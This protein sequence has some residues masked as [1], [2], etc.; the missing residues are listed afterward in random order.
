MVDKQLLSELVEADY[1]DDA[2]ATLLKRGLFEG[3][4]SKRWVALGSMPNNQSV[5]HAQQ[6]T[7]AAALVEKFTNGLDAI[8]LR[9]CKAQAVD[10]RSLSAPNNMSRAVHKWFG[11][12]NEKT[13]QEIRTLAEENLVLYAT[14]SKSRPCVSVYDAGEGQLPEN[15]PST[16]CS[17]IYGSDE[18]SYKGAVPFVQGRFNMGGTGVLPFC[19]DDRKMQLIVSRV[20]SDVVKSQHEWGFTVFCFFPSRQAPSWKYLVGADGKIM[21]AGAEPLG[22]LP[23]AGAKSGEICAPR[24]RKVPH[25]T[26]IKMYDYK[27]PRS[28]VC[29][30]LFK[31]LE[32]YLLRPM[33][34]LRIVE[35]RPEYK[36]NVMGVTVWDRFS[37]WAARGKLEEGF[38][39]GAGI[40]IKLSSGET[41]PAE[42]RVFKADADAA[43]DVEHPQTGLRALINGQSHARRDT[44]FFKSKAVDKEHIGGSMLVTLDCS[45]LGQT[46]R[47]ALFMSNRETF[48]EDPLLTELFKKLQN[49]L[50]N[51]EGL[52]A[53]DKK[54]YLEKIAKAT[55]D[56]DGINA[57][58]EL[59]STDP[60]L[61][62]LFG[63]MTQGKVAAKTIAA[64]VAGLKVEGKAP[65]FEG[66]EFPSY[67]KRKD[68]STSV[69][70]ELPQ[71]DEA[72][73]SFLTDVKNNYFIR[74]RNKGK[75]EFS[76]VMEPT[77]RLFNGR[78]TFTFHADKHKKPVGTVFDTGV[79]IS[80]AGHGPWKLSIK[81]KVA[82]P[83]ERKENEAPEPK[84][85]TDAA[86]SRPDIIDVHTGLEATPITV[87]KVPGTERLQLLVN[88]DSRLLTEAKQRR[89]PE[90]AIAV[91]FVFKYGLA[92]VA[93]GL[94]DAA[95]RTTEWSTN[96]VECRERI[97]KAAAGVAR[98]I[99]PLCLTLPKKLPKA[100]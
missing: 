1:E 62:D 81:I 60:A 56:D 78:L 88:V 25:G 9:R 43:E 27:A 98:V 26:L 14:G 34:P 37:T 67:F 84:P 16:F 54:R 53:L 5:V 70:I 50:R 85:K 79:T 74:S 89:A 77:F 93:M 33:L 48:R 13:Q 55:T 97:S 28:N 21:T 46:S 57:L 100:A 87:D 38:E 59:L 91:E 36:A 95:K 75:C 92:L 3:A 23:K 6:S 12:L 2:I 49:E 8:L 76:G 63:S 90:E 19:G 71:N 40:Q 72:R 22:L 94:L 66:T 68:G 30:E 42:V 24:E 35:C 64:A 15:F 69:E 32:E 73:V 17:L 4:N 31:K 45:D 7:P 39:D 96:E 52:I 80:D 11:D 44:Q 10:P 99:V 86:P 51:H 41:V 18:G 29:G 65:K 58:E 83:R 20:P 82:P 47:N 61:A